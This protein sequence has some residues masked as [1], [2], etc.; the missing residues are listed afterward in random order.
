MQ[1]SIT[2]GAMEMD[3]ALFRGLSKVFMFCAKGIAATSPHGTLSNYLQAF[4]SLS[5]GEKPAEA[6]ENSKQERTSE[7]NPAITAE[8]G[9]SKEEPVKTTASTEEKKVEA[10]FMNQN[11]VNVPVNTVSFTPMK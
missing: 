3:M 7:K 5:K 9:K 2:K 8:A 10:N 4:N 1:T 6:P 11:F